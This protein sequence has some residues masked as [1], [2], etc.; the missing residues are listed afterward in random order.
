MST[1]HQLE[2]ELKL[3]YEL[4]QYLEYFERKYA[5]P[6]SPKEPLSQALDKNE[7]QDSL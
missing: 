3:K 6:K 7:T 1:E 5:P 4:N 2:K